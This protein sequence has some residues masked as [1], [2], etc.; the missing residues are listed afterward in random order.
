MLESNKQLTY[1]GD[2]VIEV[3]KEI[4]IILVSLHKIGSYYGTKIQEYGEEKYRHEYERETTRFID[5]WGVTHK[6]AN[7]RKILSGKFDNT[8]DVD[9]MDDLEKAMEGLENWSKPINKLER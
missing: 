4:E 6:L 3:L 9:N 8:L 7:I 5:E 1:S 2:E